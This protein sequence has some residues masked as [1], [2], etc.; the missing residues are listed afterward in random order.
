VDVLA[1]RSHHY[2]ALRPTMDRQ[3]SGLDVGQ[4]CNLPFFPRSWQVANLLHNFCQ[5][6]RVPVSSGLS[7]TV[8]S[9]KTANDRQ[10]ELR[11]FHFTFSG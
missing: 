10:S 5:D 8:A 6:R 11:S 1:A 4:V 3:K 2:D 7:G 9:A